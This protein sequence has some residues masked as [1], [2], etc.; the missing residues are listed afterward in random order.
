MLLPEIALAR[1]ANQFAERARI[2]ARMSEA[3]CGYPIDKAPGIAAL[4]RATHFSMLGHAARPFARAHIAPDENKMQGYENPATLGQKQHEEY[5]GGTVETFNRDS[6][7]PSRNSRF[8][9]R[10]GTDEDSGD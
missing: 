1:R 7:L 3:T 4:A 8:D 5:Q 2:V 10:T 9:S 6:R